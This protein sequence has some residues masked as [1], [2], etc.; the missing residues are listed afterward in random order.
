M[1]ILFS[2]EYSGQVF[3][4]NGVMM[5]TVVTNTIGLIDLLELRLGLHHEDIPIYERMAH[6]YLL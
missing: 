5:D 3:T 2:Q 1:K 6:Y 4:R